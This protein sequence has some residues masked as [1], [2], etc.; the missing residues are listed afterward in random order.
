MNVIPLG[1]NSADS[2]RFTREL[3]ALIDW[4]FS[5]ETVLFA[6]EI[7]GLIEIEKINLYQRLPDKE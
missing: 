3:R 2:Q 7:M 1:K 4:A 5:D 6:S